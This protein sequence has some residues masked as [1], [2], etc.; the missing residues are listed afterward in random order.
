MNIENMHDALNHLDDDMIEAVDKLR[1]EKTQIKKLHRKSTWI[2]WVSIAACLCLVV[3]VYATDGFGLLSYNSADDDSAT[4]ETLDGIRDEENKIDASGATQNETETVSTDEM[5]NCS[6]NESELTETNVSVTD[7]A[8]RLFKASTEKG[9]NTLISPLSVLSALAMTAN[10]AKGETLTQMETVLGMPTDELNNYFYSYLK[11]LPQGEDYKL[12]LANSIWFTNHDRFRVNQDFLQ[13]NADYF[14]ADIYRTP[15][16]N[17]TLK[18]INSW[19]KKETDGMIPEILDKIPKE[20]VMYLVNALA[21]EA[22]WA[23]VYEKEQVH[24]GIFTLEDGTTQDVEYMYSEE[25]NYLE[26][27]KATGFLKYYKECKYAFVAMLPKEGVSVS[28]YVASLD[29]EHVNALITNRTNPTVNAAIPKFESEYNT[30]MSEVLSDMG[31]DIAFNE[32]KADFSGL[33]TSTAGN[34]YINRVLHKTFI[35]VAEQ[36]TKAGAATVVEMM[37]ECAFEVTDTK[38]VYLD[39]PFVYMLIDCETNIPFFIGTMMDV[40][41]E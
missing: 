41:G 6:M 37:D 39:R 2:R 36:G 15:F 31:M 24:F 26:D 12:N 33:G 19:V 25:S 34:I 27:E 17:S 3:S 10:G 5:S 18:D 7:F 8:V 21:F 4:E 11:V 38:T 14:D 16:D 40:N 1:N 28:D 23:D 32:D 22:E 29:G 20:A 35:S 13:L 30:E 9:K